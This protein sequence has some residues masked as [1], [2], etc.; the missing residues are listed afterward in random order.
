MPSRIIPPNGAVNGSVCSRAAEH[1]KQAA[2][3]HG[4]ELR[5]ATYLTKSEAAQLLRCSARFLERAVASG[6]L[7]VLKPTGKFWRVRRIDL[8]AFLD[9]GATIGGGE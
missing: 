9:S 7:K 4:A 8:D 3:L 6:R 1:L 5:N 2:T